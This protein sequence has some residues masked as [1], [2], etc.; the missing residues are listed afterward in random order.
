ME[1]SLPNIDYDY[2]GF[3]PHT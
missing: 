3:K 2:L 1:L